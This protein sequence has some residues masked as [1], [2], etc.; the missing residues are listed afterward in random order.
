MKVK[1][2]V[3][4]KGKG[5]SKPYVSFIGNS[6][7]DVTGSMYLIRFKKYVTLLDC[8]L[9]QLNDPFINYKRNIEQLKKIK[10]KEIDY[11]ILSHCHIDHSGLIPALYAKGCQAH[12]YVP[13]GCIPF[14]KLLW[15]DSMKIM[16][17]DCRK[18]SNHGLKA[19][20]FYTT[21]D[22]D[23]TINRCIEVDYFEEHFINQDMFFEYYPAGHII[24]SAQVV[25][26]LNEGFVKKRI[27][28]TGDIGE[29]KRVYTEPRI[30]LPFVDLL[31][32]ENT[33][34]QPTRPSKIKDRIKDIEKI[35]TISEQSNKIL[36]PT[37]S[38][39][40]TQEILTLLY[41]MTIDMDVPIYLDS[42]LAQKLC[43]IWDDEVFQNEIMKMPNLHLIN[44]WVESQVLQNENK[45]CIILAGSGFLT[46]GRSL[47]HL[48]T[49]LPD[50]N[51][52]VIFCGFS[53]ENN[54]A[55]QIKIGQ[56]IIKIDNDYVF[57][58]ARI[59]CLY[60][61]SSHASYE[62]LLDY[63]S[64]LRYNKIALVHGDIRYKPKFCN[65]LQDRLHSQGNAAK[66]VCINEGTKIYI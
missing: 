32:G 6:A 66:V 62:E 47:P 24:H 52:H 41:D 65:T 42:P 17:S 57:N 10:P 50:R 2:I 44:S 11:I 22:I 37:F 19:N 61:F 8:G 15:E 34:N 60:S 51:N 64:E 13:K 23:K 4:V 59:T 31:I 3:M 1:F 46:A 27:G 20:P 9:I 25:L 38:L 48:K 21:E 63:Y 54:L 58:N 16:E 30:D 53:G 36:I 43:D 26:T 49:L 40:R 28:Y 45:H 55:S 5:T 7:I 12:A 18:L 33:Y 56:K 29:G 39:G 35:F 14:L